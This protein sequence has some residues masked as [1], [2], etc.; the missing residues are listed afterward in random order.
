[1]LRPE[2]MTYNQYVALVTL[3]QLPSITGR[4]LS[5][6]LGVTEAAGS[7]IVKA[8]LADDLITNGATP[9]SG[10]RRELHLTSAGEDK[11]A[12]C[13]RLL[14]HSLDDNAR[15]IGIDPSSLASAIRDLHAIGRLHYLLAVAWF[16]ISYACMGNFTRL[17][18][19]HLRWL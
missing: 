5:K 4:T 12:H 1:M 2:G 14:G 15:A 10:N 19:P 9:G 7:G 17:F 11:S 16:T 8:L 13:A 6:S 18:T 3:G